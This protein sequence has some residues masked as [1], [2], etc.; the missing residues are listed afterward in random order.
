[1]SESKNIITCRRLADTR[2]SPS[3]F[4]L[5]HGKSGGS[6]PAFP[7][8]TICDHELPHHIPVEIASSSKYYIREHTQLHH[9]HGSVGVCEQ[10]PFPDLLADEPNIRSCELPSR[11]CVVEMCPQIVDKR[12]KISLLAS[13]A[14]TV[15]LHQP[16]AIAVAVG[17][18][19][20]AP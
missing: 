6:G 17:G 16:A 13:P 12:I 4:P 5:S 14:V 18:K 11:A 7:F 10:L 15:H 2:I 20:P 19:L 1:M 8:R 3:S 9:K